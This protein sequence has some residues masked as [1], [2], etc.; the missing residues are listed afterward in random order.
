MNLIIEFWYKERP[1]LGNKLISL[2]LPLIRLNRNRFD[3]IGSFIMA[4][5]KMSWE[6][7]KKKE[8]KKGM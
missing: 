2:S 7:L 5:G 6:V 3:R 1:R 8:Y 4:P